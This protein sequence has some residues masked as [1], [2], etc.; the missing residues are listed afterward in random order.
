MTC[1]H[2]SL[3]P[4][5]EVIDPSPSWPGSYGNGALADITLDLALRATFRLCSA[6]ARKTAK[7]AHHQPSVLHEVGHTITNVS[8]D[9]KRLGPTTPRSSRA[10]AA[11]SPL[12]PS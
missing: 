11:L 10:A 12:L 5:P 7:D 4:S 9:D 6:R 3:A 1:R 8:P 2:Y